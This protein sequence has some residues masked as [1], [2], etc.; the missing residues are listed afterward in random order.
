MKKGNASDPYRLR[1]HKSFFVN[2][3]TINKTDEHNRAA[4]PIISSDDASGG[5]RSSDYYNNNE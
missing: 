5:Y 3:T 4:K 2:D 1:P